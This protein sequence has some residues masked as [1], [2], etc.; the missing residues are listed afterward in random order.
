[1]AQKVKIKAILAAAHSIKSVWEANPDLKMADIAVSDFIAMYGAAEGLAK[2]Y[3][4]K[5]IGMRGLK[6]NRDNTVQKLNGLVTRL[7]SGMRFYYGPDSPQY[8]QSGGTRASARKRPKRKSRPA[9]PT[10]RS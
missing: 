10:H 5:R 6:I 3:A 7:R 2:E 8:E 9:V 1:M 4:K